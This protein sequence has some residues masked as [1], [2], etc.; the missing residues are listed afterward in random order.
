M[1]KRISHWAWVIF[2]LISLVV[3]LVWLATST[4]G[5]W[6]SESQLTPLLSVD[7]TQP[8]NASPI[9]AEDGSAK[10]LQLRVAIAPVI[11]PAKSI[12]M[13]YGLVEYLAE[14]L[15]REPVI[16]QR[17]T[18]GEINTIV[19]FGR[20]DLAMVCTYQYI[21]GQQDFGMKML[22]IPQ[23]RGSATYNSYIIVEKENPAESLL[24][25]EDSRFASADI[26]SN[27]GWLYPTTWLLEKG[28]DPNSFFSEHIFSGSHDSSLMAVVTGYVQGAA[29]DSLVY[30][31]MAQEDPEI[32]IAT[33]II[34]KSPPFG[35]P[36]FV[37]PREIDFELEEDL[38]SLLLTMHKS[39]EGQEILLTMGIDR[40][41]EPVDENY[42]SVRRAAE[43]MESWR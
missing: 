36:P 14:K 16:I 13:Y 17:G 30:D 26:L 41:L 37:V 33:R 32:Q 8:E 11:S 25:L 29:I 31:R 23:I 6:K 42:D 7:L 4:A 15:D 3:V 35:M 38:R 34:D 39:A 18:Y 12:E 43:V 1:E 2:V 10:G 5:R 22:A 21:R 9:M 40:F 24:D 28:K 27:T 20:C 19:N